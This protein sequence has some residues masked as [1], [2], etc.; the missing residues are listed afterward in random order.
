MGYIVGV[1][2]LD[3]EVLGTGGAAGA[4]L[5]M[6]LGALGTTLRAPVGVDDGEGVL[7]V[8]GNVPGDW[9]EGVP[10]AGVVCVAGVVGLVEGVVAGA[11]A[12]P[13]GGTGAGLSVEPDGQT[14]IVIA[15]AA[16]AA[17][18]PAVAAARTR[19][20]RAARRRTCWNVPGGGAS[21]V[22]PGRSRTARS[23]S[24][25][26]SRPSSAGS[27]S[28]IKMSSPVPRAGVPVPRVDRI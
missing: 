27:M 19:R 23:S 1:V 3:A 7:G 22:T 2:A 18:A 15:V 20:R 26:S 6:R 16:M 13:S 8:L 10:D 14:A 5:V 28:V 25:S 21:T 11:T 9:S 24:F 4:E 17:P 12:G